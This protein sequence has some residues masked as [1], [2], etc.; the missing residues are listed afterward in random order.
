MYVN[1]SADEQGGAVKCPI[2][3]LTSPGVCS[4]FRS[5]LATSCPISGDSLCNRD[6]LD[7]FTLTSTTRPEGISRRRCGLDDVRG[8]CVVRH[9]CG[10]I[11]ET[12][13][14]ASFHAVSPHSLM[15][16]MEDSEK[17]K[18]GQKSSPDFLLAPKKPDR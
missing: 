10:T 13:I 5:Y 16:A 1:K 17:Q 9:Q 15:A 18:T 6:H 7:L 2:V 14:L 11:S 12:V 8:T 3:L 4:H